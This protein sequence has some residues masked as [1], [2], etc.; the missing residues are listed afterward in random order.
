MLLLVADQ[1]PFVPDNSS[2]GLM[3]AQFN[4]FF[5]QKI[6]DMRSALNSPGFT[7]MSSP[8]DDLHRDSD[9]IPSLV[10]E[11][12]WFS[13]ASQTEIEQIILR[14]PQKSGPLDLLTHWLLLTCLP[15]LLPSITALVNCSL[16][17]GMPSLYKVAVVTPLIKKR[18][19]DRNAYKKFHSCETALI[20]V[21]N[22]VLRAADSGKV[23]ALVLLDMS[24]AFDT[25]DHK[26]LITR[27]KQMGVQWN[28]SK[29]NLRVP[30]K[31]ST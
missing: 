7:D 26:I 23:T 1:S 3:A 8:L 20:S 27:M 9:A 18:G 17:N 24:A 2:P 11:L 15:V 5:L 13:P 25:V 29:S 10:T 21:Q 28:L 4:D 30:K 19:S 12:D 31:S 22:A 16:L 14:S 6:S